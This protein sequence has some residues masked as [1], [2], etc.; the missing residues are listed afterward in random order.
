MNGTSSGKGG[1]PPGLPKTGGRQKGTPN[2]MTS[3]LRQKLEE[4]GCDPVTELVTIARGPKT[5]V[6]QQ[7]HIYSSLLRHTHPLPKPVDSS[8]EENI[9]NEP[10]ITLDD[11]LVWA[12]YLIERFGSPPP[13]RE[14]ESVVQEGGPSPESTD[15]NNEPQT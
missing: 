10:E 8:D 12:Y 14:S 11:A 1:R 3:A 13:K 9:K 6:G 15:K 4:L 5:D 2:K 7:V